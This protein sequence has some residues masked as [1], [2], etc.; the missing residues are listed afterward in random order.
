M[1]SGVIQ[2]SALGPILF[3]AY[4][5]DLAPAAYGQ[6]GD[7]KSP[8][9]PRP[10]APPPAPQ[11]GHSTRQSGAA[12]R[13]QGGDQ[14]SK[15]E[16]TRQPHPDLPHPCQ[17]VDVH[18]S[19]RGE[20]TKRGAATSTDSLTTVDRTRSILSLYADN[21][22]FG[23]VVEQDEDQTKFQGVID[24]LYDWSQEWKL[25]FNLGKCKIM[26]VGRA[27]KH[28]NYAMGGTPLETTGEEKDVGVYITDDLKPSR[29]CAEVVKRANRALGQLTRGLSYIPLL[30][31]C[32]PPTRV[33]STG[34]E[35][36]SQ[37]RRGSLGGSAEEGRPHGQRPKG[38]LV[39]GEVGRA[40][41]RLARGEEA[42][43]G[44]DPDLQ[45]PQRCRQDR[46]VSLF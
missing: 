36:V 44:Y 38:D 9:L 16:A 35:P 27:N 5:N 19:Q 22:K 2:G 11:S 33:C 3:L 14:H 24:R 6:E 7:H 21:T 28:Y 40:K 8:D 31:P 39:R 13:S 42:Q 29:Q 12:D 34:L 26:H 4:I 43:G 46:P 23:M 32:P 30:Q 45:D 18:G 1:G 25:L 15:E 41:T 20:L 10:A 17:A 37:R